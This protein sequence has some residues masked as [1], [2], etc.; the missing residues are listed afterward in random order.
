[1]QREEV[2][3]IDLPV[4]WIP[5]P[6]TG[7]QTAR[8]DLLSVESNRIDLAKVSRKSA[9]T[10]ALRYAPY[11]SSGVVGTRHNDVTVDLKAPYTRLVTDK[12][13]LA[14]TLFEVP[15]PECRVARAR[16][17]CIGVGHLQTSHS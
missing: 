1:M 10:L 9:Q 2:S 8:C 11:L 7:I 4:S 13:V 12:N 3:Q 16:N 6:N 14:K 17:C 5:Y 15:Y